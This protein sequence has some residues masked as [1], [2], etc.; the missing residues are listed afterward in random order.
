MNNRLYICAFADSRYHFSMDRLMFQAKMMDIFEDGFFYDETN[1]PDEFIQ[2]FGSYLN[3][4]VRGYGFWV[5]KPY[6]ILDALNTIKEND[7]LLYLDTGCYLNVKGK[8]RLMQY[9]DLVKKN[10]SGFVVTNAGE[11][12]LEYRWTKGDLLDYF[13]VR[14]NDSIIRTPQFQGG[15]IF[16][17]KNSDTV[18]LIERWLDVYNRHFHLADDSPSLSPN[19]PG[20]KEHRHD[21]SILSILLKLHGTSVIPIEE[22]WCEGNWETLIEEYPILQ[23]R[24][25]R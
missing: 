18:S 21:Q 24:D 25:L 10:E 20:F 15:T 8:K 17:R 9:F 5:W 12:N 11:D 2:R 13:K 1:L 7:L 14:S 23:A 19:L 4:E 22:C 6:I 16:I 3:T